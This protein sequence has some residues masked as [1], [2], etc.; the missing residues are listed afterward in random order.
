MA[1]GISA[2]EQRG[3][4]AANRPSPAPR[5]PPSLPDCTE[6][7]SLVYPN[8]LPEAEV[9]APIEVSFRESAA[10][11]WERWPLEPNALVL[12]DTSPG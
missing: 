3:E 8:K 12:C 7:P 4:D 1:T 5:Y 6:P 11:A 2:H 9:L 10:G